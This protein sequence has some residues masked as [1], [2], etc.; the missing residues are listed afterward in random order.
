M[1]RELRVDS[2]DCHALA[3]FNSTHDDSPAG[4]LAASENHQYEASPSLGQDR[5]RYISSM[6]DNSH[7]KLLSRQ[8]RVRARLEGTAHE[9]AEWIHGAERSVWGMRAVES[10]LLSAHGSRHS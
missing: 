8:D 6:P 2:G 9:A 10:K 4:S 3:A 1:H 5:A 7:R